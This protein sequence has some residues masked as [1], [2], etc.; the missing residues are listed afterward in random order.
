MR[1]ITH[2]D[3]QFGHVKCFQSNDVTVLLLKPF[4]RLGGLYDE[5]IICR[6]NGQVFKRVN[7]GEHYCTVLK[8]K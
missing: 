3:W 7:D 4:A 6:K 8:L 5:N 2:F 1:S